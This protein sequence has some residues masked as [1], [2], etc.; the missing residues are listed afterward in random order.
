M[1]KIFCIVAL[2]C[3]ALLLNLFSGFSNT[4]SNAIVSVQS[5]IEVEDN[6]SHENE[7]R[8]ELSKELKESSCLL[9]R[10]QQS[11]NSSWVQRITRSDNKLLQFLLLKEHNLLRKVSETVSAYQ[12]I[13]HLSLL[14]RSG[15]HIYALRKIII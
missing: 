1:K 14:C 10:V 9:P 3:L 4:D 13:N 11:S 5:I 6:S 15:Y 8:F 2:F 12:T 7:V